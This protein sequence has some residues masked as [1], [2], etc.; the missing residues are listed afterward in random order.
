MDLQAGGEKN[1][2]IVA[3]N[4]G[5]RRRTGGQTPQRGVREW[6]GAMR[7]AKMRS[8]LDFDL[9]LADTELVRE[10][11][12][13]EEAE[14]RAAVDHGLQEAEEQLLHKRLRRARDIENHR[15]QLSHKVN[16]RD[17]H[18]VNGEAFTEDSTKPLVDAWRR[19][20][21]EPAGE[22]LEFSARERA[23]WQPIS[24][25][26]VLPQQQHSHALLYRQVGQANQAGAPSSLG[27]AP[28]TMSDSQTLGSEN[29]PL[30]LWNAMSKVTTDSAANRGLYNRPRS[31]VRQ[32]IRHRDA[33]NAFQS[34]KNASSVSGGSTL[35]QRPGSAPS[36]GRRRA[37]AS[38][39]FCIGSSPP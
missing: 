32:L 4:A 38:A 6:I 16:Y 29:D 36:S 35:R 24:E 22:D 13:S 2:E 10:D 1:N 11:V 21:V 3:G 26:T 19:K 17:A 34:G 33:N 23:L 31:G 15:F 18:L 5:A 7:S 8:H 30:K 25:G 39:G 27:Q 20:K 37:R 12:S 28:S 14:I 9:L